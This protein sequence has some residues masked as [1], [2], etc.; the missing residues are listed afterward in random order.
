M[1][2]TRGSLARA[3]H[4]RTTDDTWHQRSEL[5]TTVLAI[6][7]SML[8]AVLIILIFIVLFATIDDLWA[9]PSRV[10]EFVTRV[11]MPMTKGEQHGM[12]QL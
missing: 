6:A 4:L 5:H 11:I 8:L 2:G 7:L 3:K 12:S 9:I 10:R 1:T